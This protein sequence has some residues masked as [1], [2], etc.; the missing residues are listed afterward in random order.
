MHLTRR[1]FALLLP[2]VAALPSIQ[3][4]MAQESP[5]WSGVFLNQA[6]L[7]TL[8]KRLHTEPQATAFAAL[9]A[10]ADANLDRQPSV[11]KVWY[12]PGY[13]HDAAGHEKA[14]GGLEGD[15]NAAYGLALAYRMTGDSRYAAAAVRLIDAW[16]TGVESM[17][18]K[19]DST[20]T[21]SYH[22][23]AMILAASLLEPYHPWPSANRATLR[24]FIR[25]KALPMNTMARKNNWGNWGLVLVFSSA[26]Y[27]Q[28]AALFQSAVD[29]W[30]SFIETQI[31]ADGH[32]PEEVG[33]NGGVGERGIWYSHFCL[34]PQTIAAEIA[35]VNGVDLYEYRSP[36]GHTLRS[37][38][39][40][41][42][43]WTHDPGT[44]PYFHPRGANDKQLGTDYISYWE[45]LNAHW[46]NPIAT[47]MIRARRPLTAEHSAP[48]LT[49][50]HGDLLHDA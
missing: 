9:K 18:D 23:P 10:D 3:S 50:T 38:Y 13:Y 30:K 11:P 19:D 1:R 41:L 25:Q 29:R 47:A 17:S 46:P 39:E 44:F 24:T 21:F 43:P 4:L 22:F 37:A 14:K 26:A 28:D 7:H 32:L 36:S 2:T 35:R 31:A 27:L 40:R 6:R 12:V 5:R 49:F 20:L 48:Y 42:V 8:R 34:M 16:A 33:R 15:A 45:I